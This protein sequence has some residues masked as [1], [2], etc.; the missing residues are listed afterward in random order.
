KLFQLPAELAAERHRRVCLV[1]DEFQ[2]VLELDPN[3]PSL[4]RAV[5]Q[6]HA[7]VAHVALGS[8]RSM[9]GG[10]LNDANEPFWR[11]AKQLELGVIA[12]EDFAPCIRARFET[13]G[14]GVA[15]AAVDGVLAITGG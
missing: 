4:M 11:S 8:K 10:L 1:F 13:T 3:L 15:D 9:M 14:K 5:F 6:T 2:E 7:D 12:P